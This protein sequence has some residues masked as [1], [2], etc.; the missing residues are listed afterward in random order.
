MRPPFLMRSVG[1]ISDEEAVTE[2]PVRWNCGRAESH[3]I[4]GNQEFYS[5]SD[6]RAWIA[7]PPVI[8]GNSSSNAAPSVRARR[9]AAKA[10]S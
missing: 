8:N 3:R 9:A 5:L 6:C 10:A 7:S 1:W 4:V 2:G